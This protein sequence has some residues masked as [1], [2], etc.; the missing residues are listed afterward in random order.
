MRTPPPGQ[1]AVLYA[2]D[3]L[4]G[5]SLVEPTPDALVTFDP[6]LKAIPD[7]AGLADRYRRSGASP[8]AAAGA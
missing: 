3:R 4:L 5:C 1:A 7:L 8:D 6:R 2:G